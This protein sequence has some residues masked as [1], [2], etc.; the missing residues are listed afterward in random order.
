M[1]AAP[2]PMAAAASLVSSLPWLPSSTCNSPA[3]LRCAS[4]CAAASPS[5]MLLAA[6]A[7]ASAA[8]TGKVK[9]DRRERLRVE[10]LGCVLP[11]VTCVGWLS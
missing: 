10:A 3:G 11:S 9:V 8:G 5:A 6:S 4:S 7:S 2:P 1:V